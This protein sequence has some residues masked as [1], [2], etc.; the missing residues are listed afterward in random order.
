M[1]SNSKNLAILF[2]VMVPSALTA[3]IYLQAA[4][5]NDEN[6]LLLLR[7]TARLAF[8]VYLVIFIARP[9]RQLLRNSLTLWLL[10]ERR[11]LGIAFA[12]MHTVHLGLIFTLHDMASLLERPIIGTLFGAT[13]YALMYLMLLT[14]FNAPARA[15]GPTKWRRLHKTGLYFIGFVFI[16]TL[17]PEPGEPVYIM[18]RA[19]LTILTGGALVIRLTAWFA[20]RRKQ[21]GRN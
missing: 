4:G 21:R 13:A 20:S 10:K 17:L 16:A 1:S 5:F 8:F 12:A 18:E 3:Y 14:S 2:G 15:L 7:L 11:S 6:L 9:L 19:W